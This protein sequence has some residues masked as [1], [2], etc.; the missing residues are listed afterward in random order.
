MGAK[1]RRNLTL[2]SSSMF[3]W[4]LTM[5]SKSPFLISKNSVGSIVSA[6]EV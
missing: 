1:L 4:D 2:R 6:V 5:R 3:S